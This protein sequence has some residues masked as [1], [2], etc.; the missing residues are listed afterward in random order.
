MGKFQC[1]LCERT[2]DNKRAIIVH[3]RYHNLKF[4]EKM[5][6]I[7]R[8]KKW[9]EQSKQKKREENNVNWKG[10]EVQYN[11]L[12]EWIRNEEKRI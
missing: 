7:L 12:H 5:S 9:S 3:K 6:K 4:R 2:F 1:N 10:D 11:A 8:G